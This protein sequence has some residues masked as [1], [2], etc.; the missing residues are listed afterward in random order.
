MH[1]IALW[2]QH[3]PRAR[4]CH[5]KVAVEIITKVRGMANAIRKH[6]CSLFNITKADNKDKHYMRMLAV[7]VPGAIGLSDEGFSDDDIRTSSLS[8]SVGTGRQE[9]WSGPC[10]W[11]SATPPVL[12]GRLPFSEWWVSPR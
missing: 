5:I 10:R 1:R 3:P 6:W 7:L 4:F 11:V 8:L 9:G 2:R 12:L